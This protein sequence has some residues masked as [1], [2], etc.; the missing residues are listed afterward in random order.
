MEKLSAQLHKVMP[1]MILAAAIGIW[2]LVLQNAG[3]LPKENGVFLTNPYLPT[4]FG[5]VKSDVS[6]VVS[7][8]NE[9]KVN[10]MKILSRNAGS[11]N[12]CTIDGQEYNSLDVTVVGPK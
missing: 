7:I 10:L 2:A 1:L 6:G 12:S 9:V 5:G 11:H 3:V 4:H 8:D